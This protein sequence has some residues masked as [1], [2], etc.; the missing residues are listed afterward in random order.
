MRRTTLSVDDVCVG[1]A[2]LFQM[3]NSIFLCW[4]IK[5]IKINPHVN[6]VN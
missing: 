4:Q 2:G 1:S 3:I 6:P 5:K